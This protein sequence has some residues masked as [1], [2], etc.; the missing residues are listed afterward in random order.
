MGKPGSRLMTLLVVL[1]LMGTA[2]SAWAQNF[3]ILDERL[4][5][6]RHGY[7]VIRVWGSHHEMGY[8]MGAAFAGDILAGLAEVKA[9]TG[10]MYPAI[11]AVMQTTVWLPIEIEDEISGIVDGVKSV[12]P[13]EPLDALDVKVMNTYSDWSYAT[14]CRSHSCWGDFVQDPVKTLSTRRL[15]YGTPFDIAL[16]HVLC[17]WDPDD[18]SVRWVNMAMPGY[19]AVITGINAYGTLVSLHDYNSSASTNSGLVARSVA[20][21]YILTGVG[22]TP[23]ADHRSWAQG[24]LSNMNVATSTFLNYFVP[25]GQGGVFTCPS[26]GPC[27]QLRTPQTDYF[28]GQVLI[29]TNS[30]TDGHSVPGDGDFMH[31]YYQAGG[32][33]SLQSHFD[34]M[35][36]DGL[37]LVSVEVR[38]TE[39]M[40]IW[41]HGRGRADRI[42]VQ[43]ATLFPQG[44]GG[45][46]SSSGSSSSGSGAS[47]SSDTDPQDADESCGC[48]T[49]GCRT[50]G[51]ATPT[52]WL[53]LGL[54]LLLMRRRRQLVS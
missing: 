21:R 27:G 30:Q 9:D 11:R 8:A 51:G 32:V 5:E 36:T 38:G 24:E 44:T 16:H 10:S 47:G 18:G 39:D 45:S 19:V 14:A 48:R 22:S 3:Q 7:T 54:A 26:G 42:E 37:H 17:A 23:I 28:G 50:G 20:T 13:S 33:K 12:H 25:E 29:T 15:D 2:T 35:G 31:A 6:N 1:F 46:S 53:W 40:T 34:L 49:P 43:W 52:P 4:D 41:A